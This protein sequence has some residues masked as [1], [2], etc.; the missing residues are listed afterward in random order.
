MK[1]IPDWLRLGANVIGGCCRVSPE[2]IS[3]IRD[4]VE[5]VLLDSLEQ[6]AK[7]VNLSKEW[8]EINQ[9]WRIKDDKE[10][11][12]KDKRQKKREKIVS[13]PLDFGRMFAL[14]GAN[15][16]HE[17][18]RHMHAILAHFNVHVEMSEKE[19]EEENE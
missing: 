10:K 6:R 15:S 12:K 5:D 4:K 19:L 3:K 1:H 18:Q 14:P 8:E 13:D 2:M 17:V 7:S 9:Q 16:Q 11:D